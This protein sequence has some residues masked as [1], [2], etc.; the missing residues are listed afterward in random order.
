MKDKILH[1]LRLMHILRDKVYYNALIRTKDKEKLVKQFKNTMFVIGMVALFS[2]IAIDSFLTFAERQKSKPLTTQEQLTLLSQRQ[3][4][5][6]GRMEKYINRQEA[7]L[8]RLNESR[9]FINGLTYEKDS[10]KIEGALP[11]IETVCGEEC[12]V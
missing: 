10:D 2:I 12:H 9:L 11:P 8:E 1:Y 5:N 3:E 7:I 6:E 4:K